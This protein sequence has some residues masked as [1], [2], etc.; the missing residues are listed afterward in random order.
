MANTVCVA[1]FNYNGLYEA[2]LMADIIQW[3]RPVWPF[4]AVPVAK[5][6]ITV[7]I[8]QLANV[9]MFSNKIIS[10]FMNGQIKRLEKVVARWDVI[11]LVYTA[12]L[13]HYIDVSFI[14][15]RWEVS[16]Y[17]ISSESVWVC[18][19]HCEREVIISHGRFDVIQLVRV[20]RQKFD[21]FVVVGDVDRS[22]LETVTQTS[23]CT[24]P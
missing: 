19:G 20:S 6:D 21:D 10:T 12:S 13:L 18:A 1:W 4:L 22:L 5:D 23:V 8:T 7:G 2:T 3:Q 15:C 16:A 24:M 17:S 9:V 14:V 11:T